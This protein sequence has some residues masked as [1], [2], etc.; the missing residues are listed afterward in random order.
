MDRVGNLNNAIYKNTGRDDMFGI[1]F[2]RKHQF[3]CL[4]DGGRGRHAHEGTEIS[5]SLVIG[6][7]AKGVSDCTLDQ[8]K[9]GLEPRLHYRSTPIKH[10]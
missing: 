1:N 6:Q 8:S 7:V 10:P 2:T 5:G 9:I 4:N 3:L